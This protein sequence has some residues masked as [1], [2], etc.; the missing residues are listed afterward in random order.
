M[1]LAMNTLKISVVVETYAS[2]PFKK[3]MNNLIYI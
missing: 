1:A 2:D 3:K